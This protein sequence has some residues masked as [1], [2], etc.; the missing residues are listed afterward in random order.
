V[1]AKNTEGTTAA[2]AT[3]LTGVKSADGG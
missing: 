2:C 3:R 1:G